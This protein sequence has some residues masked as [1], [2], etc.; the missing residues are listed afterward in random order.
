ML[1]NFL[2]CTKTYIYTRVLLHANFLD[3]LV[4]KNFEV[5]TASGCVNV[6]AIAARSRCDHSHHRHKCAMVVCHGSS[7][8]VDAL[9]VEAPRADK[10]DTVLTKITESWK[11]HERTTR[12]Q[13]Q[14]RTARLSKSTRTAKARWPKPPQK[15]P[16]IEGEEPT[17]NLIPGGICFCFKPLTN[18]PPPG[19][20]PYLRIR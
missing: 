14:Y 9:P 6:Y 11:H 12:R 17:P 18:Q 13:S 1:E 20:A 2:K 8:E 3:E 7:H 15:T 10:C 4:R 16:L 19:P 5:L